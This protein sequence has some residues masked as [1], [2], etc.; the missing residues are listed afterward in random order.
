MSEERKAP[1]RRARA[2]CHSNRDAYFECLTN[3]NE[4]RAACAELF[5]KFEATCMP[6]WVKHFVRQREWNR[7]KAARVTFVP[8]DDEAKA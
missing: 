5:E 7:E 1:N 2:E 4:D 6:S 3:K 8:T